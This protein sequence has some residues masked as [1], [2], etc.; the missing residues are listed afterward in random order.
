LTEKPLTARSSS[1]KSD[2]GSSIEILT[3]FKRNTVQGAL[4]GGV[5][6]YIL[7]LVTDGKEK[8]K[9]PTEEE[10]NIRLTRLEKLEMLPE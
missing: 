1:Y 5:P 6:S 2:S 10:E 7:N 3:R 8:V 9:V 4:S